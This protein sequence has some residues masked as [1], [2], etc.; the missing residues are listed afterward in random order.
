[1]AHQLRLMCPETQASGAHG[2]AERSEPDQGLAVPA[3]ASVT[4][5]Q[6]T[7]NPGPPEGPLRT[8]PAEL[9]EGAGRLG[10]RR[11]TSKAGTTGPRRAY[12]R[13]GA[14]ETVAMA[15]MFERRHYVHAAPTRWAARATSVAQKGGNTFRVPGRE[16][17]GCGVTITC[18]PAN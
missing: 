2:K 12:A 14:S 17:C 18:S 11:S 10:S 6:T 3:N 16:F 9:L 13:D 7:S 1:M 5:A 15:L 8:G 4:V